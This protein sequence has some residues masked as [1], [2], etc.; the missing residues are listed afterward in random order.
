MAVAVG[1]RSAAPG[2]RDRGDDSPALW[3]LTRRSPSSRRVTP[4]EPDLIHF[5]PAGRRLTAAR[6]FVSPACPQVC[7]GWRGWSVPLERN[8]R[9][10]PS[11]PTPRTDSS[12]LSGS[13]IQRRAAKPLRMSSMDPGFTL[14]WPPT[15]ARRRRCAPWA[16]ELVPETAGGVYSGA[17]DP[18]RGHVETG[19]RRH[20]GSKADAP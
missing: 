10:A 3:L 15:G 20:R 16:A 18:P 6:L 12:R 14:F 2:R 11:P 1:V 4:G 17:R 13:L 19:H 8:G 5:E 9:A 7:A